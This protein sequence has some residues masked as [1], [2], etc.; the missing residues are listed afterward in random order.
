MNLPLAHSARYGCPAQSY[1]EHIRN[2]TRNALRAMRAALRHYAPHDPKGPSVR[3]FLATVGDGSSFHDLGKLDV[4]NQA[5]LGGL[6]RGGSLP[7]RHEDAGVALLAQCGALEAAG[8]VSAHHQGLV[9]YEFDV[10]PGASRLA[11]PNAGPRRLATHVFRVGDA[12]TQASTAQHLSKHREVHEQLL[13]RRRSQQE[14]GLNRFDGFSR[15]VMLSCLVDADH[16]DTARHYGQDT[17]LAPAAPRWAERLAVLDNYVAS[18]PRPNEATATKAER[19]RQSLRDAL[20]KACRHEPIGSGMRSCDAVVGSGKTTALMAHLLRVAIQYRL[21]HIFVVLPYTNIIRQ[22][23]EVYREALCLP[24]ESPDLVVAEHHHQVEFKDMALRGLTTLWR[25]PI[26]VT[27]AVQ[28]FETLA[29]NRTS[30]LRKLHE[31]PGSAVFVDEAHATMPSALWPA[32]W[33]WLS[34]WVQGWNGHLVLASGSLPEFWTTPEFQRIAVRSECAV[35]PLADGLRSASRAAESRRIR[36]RSIPEPLALEDFC[37]RVEA[38]PGPR[39]V[40]VNTVQACAVLAKRMQERGVQAVQHLSTALA[41]G[42]RARVVDLI[43]SRL[44][45]ADRNWTLVAT[46]LVEAGMDFSFGAG[47]RQRCSVASLIQTGGRINRG[48][49]EMMAADVWDFDFA[50]T[51]TFP[52]NPAVEV[53]RL[54]LKDLIERGLIAGAET[55][56]DLAEVCLHAMKYEFGP[57]RQDVAKRLVNLELQMDYPTLAAEFK[58]IPSDAC[59]VLVDRA[60]AKRIGAGFPVDAREVRQ[61]SVQMYANKIDRF[62]MESVLRSVGELYVLPEG[63]AYDADGFGYM[64]GWFEREAFAVTGGYFI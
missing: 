25:A 39:L 9:R 33:R 14:S 35:R 48:G 22:S 4:D 64:A 18:R 12:G 13:G 47:F 19:M 28:F 15:R 62:G 21:R 11:R 44:S 61:R 3:E 16:G 8:L 42:D 32:S 23:V 27:T 2:V 56:T 36:F 1:E 49:K 20:Y 58:L 60:L 26:I 50:D 38:S 7:V 41:P 45:R 34:E 29:A 53:P 10:V 54:A 24:G 52:N 51:T 30:A 40:I 6:S 43:K 31:L 46:S 17:S 5:T 59:T 55:S 37:K 63:W 57:A